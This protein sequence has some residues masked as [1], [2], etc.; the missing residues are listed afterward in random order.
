MQSFLT[1][2]DR[3]FTQETRTM[4]LVL[5]GALHSL[6]SMGARLALFASFLMTALL[7][8]AGQESS[9]VFSSIE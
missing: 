4:L 5:P 8:F 7:V 3:D 1:I 2:P 9:P 6:A